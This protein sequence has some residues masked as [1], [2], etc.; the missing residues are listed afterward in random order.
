L[1]D[2]IYFTALIL[3]SIRIFCL[4]IVVPALF[5]S[6]TP[7]AVKVG[8]TLVIAYIVMPGVDYSTVSNINNIFPFIM[9][10][11]NEAAAGLTLGFVINLC[12]A[13]FRFAGNLMDLQVG[14]SMMSFFNPNTNSNT[15]LIE[16]A[17]YW[18]SIVIFFLIDGHHMIIR[19]LIESFNIIKPGNLI[20]NTD[21]IN[22]IIL[23]FIQYFAIGVKIAIPIVIIILITDLTMGLIARTV[24]QL[25]IM[26][27][28]LPVKILIGLLAFSISLPIFMKYI[29]AAY[30]Q[31]P[32][33]FQGFYKTIPL[34]LIFA[35]D[36]KTE[37]ATPKK[38]SDSRKKGQIP[39]SKEVGLALTL[40]ASTLVIVFLGQYA[41]NGFSSTMIAF[42]NNYINITLDYNSV[43]DI[44]LIAIWRIGV[45]FLPIVLPILVLGVI[46]NVVQTGALITKEPLKPDFTKLNPINGFKRMFSM[47]TVM[48]LFK[49][50]AIVSVVGYIG[51]RFVVDNY[52]SIL[53]SGN[54]NPQFMLTEIINLAVSIFF[55]ITIVMIIIAIIDY[56]FQRYQYNKDLRMTKQEIKEEYKQEEGDPQIKGKI[57][58][59]Q[60]EMAM[61]RMMQEI[62]NAT[63]V[64]T[65]PTHIAVALKY[66]EGQSAPV[67]VAKG[68]DNVAIKIKEK[69]SENKIPIIEN[70][71]LARIIF[72]EV[73]LNSEIPME[74]Y[75]AVAEVLAL[76]YKINRK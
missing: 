46:A 67:V 18:F 11:I 20:L 48:E 12:F 43:K 45:I 16:N 59:K 55:K 36:D 9:N 73:E 15:T 50:L 58:Q 8:L 39:K 2:S 23:A 1:V 47:R 5:P 63:V 41:I 31:L 17:M 75:Q 30:Q 21:S 40:L 14:F 25:N 42:L 71:P 22:I 66:E 54:S 26:V 35:S 29:I 3:V 70:K 72:S 7:N 38:K 6:S 34:L 28:G 19:A 62:P 65:N 69:A 74:M 64:V 56:I 52:M 51:Y 68:A 33:I 32:D 53:Y 57:R 13:S 44:T 10:C 37:E 60:R 27:L 4:F 61:M 24:P 76:V 49:D